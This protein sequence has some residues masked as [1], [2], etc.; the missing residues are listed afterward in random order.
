MNNTRDPPMTGAHPLKSSSSA[1]SHQVHHHTPAHLLATTLATT[2]IRSMSTT[3]PPGSRSDDDQDDQ[4][5][6]PPREDDA[7]YFVDRKLKLCTSCNNTH[8]VPGPCKKRSH[9]K[10]STEPLPQSLLKT[11]KQPRTVLSPHDQ[12]NMDISHLMGEFDQVCNDVGN[13][14]SRVDAALGNIAP[15]HNEVSHRSQSTRGTGN[16]SSMDVD[17]VRQLLTDASTFLSL[18]R[19]AAFPRPAA[20][21]ATN[22]NVQGQMMGSA[23]TSPQLRS[24]S[25]TLSKQSQ[26]SSFSQYYA[27]LFRGAHEESEDF[28]EGQQSMEQLLIEAMAKRLRTSKKTS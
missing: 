19:R 21:E 27:S 2:T 15:H 18:A 25:K 11:I 17:Q 20:D 16:P 1:A 3:N 9:S 7:R 8:I 10:V 4:G 28:E 22:N 14:K 12:S 26:Q 24:P 13:L 6:E 5:R 23:P